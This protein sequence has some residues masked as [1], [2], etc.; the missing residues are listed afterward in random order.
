MNFYT[1]SV[2]VA[3]YGCYVGDTFGGAFSYADGVIVLA[4]SRFSLSH[5]LHI[6][7]EFACEYFM[8]FNSE[9]SKYFLFSNSHQSDRAPLLWNNN[10]VPVSDFALHLGN[11]G[12]VGYNVEDRVIKK[13][14][15][16]FYCRFNPLFVHFHNVVVNCKYHLFKTL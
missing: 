16:D 14:L 12:L 5:M 8:S 9:K 1:V 7:T 4:P 2:P 10:I 6:C 15:T 11:I 13:L 3:I